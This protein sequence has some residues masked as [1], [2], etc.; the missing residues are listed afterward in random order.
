MKKNY[1]AIAALALLAFCN[2]C[3][4]TPKETKEETPAVNTIGKVQTLAGSYLGEVSKLQAEQ[5]QCTDVERM[6]TLDSVINARKLEATTLM[7]AAFD[8]LPKPLN[9]IFDQKKNNDKITVKDLRIVGVSFNELELE[10]TVEAVQSSSF[11]MPFA[12]F[13]IS[14][15][16]GTRLDVAGG[17]GTDTKLQAGQTYVFKG[18]AQNVQNLAPGFK[19]SFDEDM[20]KW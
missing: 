11:D 17:I 1:V 4:N 2:S 9:I 10:A 13:S 18:K 19:V 15:A 20:K 7:T 8:S 6:F 5:S 14:D 16:K 12:S 3:S